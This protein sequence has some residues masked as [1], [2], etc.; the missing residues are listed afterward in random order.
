MY[1]DPPSAVTIVKLSANHRYGMTSDEA[2]NR[3]NETLAVLRTIVQEANP[4]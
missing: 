1:V 3:E 2:T 4:S